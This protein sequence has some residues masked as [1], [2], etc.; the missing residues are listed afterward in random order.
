MNNS[1][2]DHLSNGNSIPI[3]KELYKYS[4]KMVQDGLLEPGI[5]RSFIT[6]HKNEYNGSQIVSDFLHFVFEL[7]YDPMRP[8][9]YSPHSKEWGRS[10]D[11]NYKIPEITSLW[12]DLS[13]DN[14][15]LMVK[16]VG[17][18]NIQSLVEQGYHFLHQAY[19]GHQTKAIEQLSSYDLSYDLKDNWGKTVEQYAK[20]DP[21]LVD[22]YLKNNQTAQ[23]FTNMKNWFVETLDKIAIYKWDKKSNIKKLQSWLNEKWNGFSDDE[24][25][26]LFSLT[27]GC[28]IRDPYLMVLNLLEDKKKHDRTR[29]P[30]WVNLKNCHNFNLAFMAIKG[31]DFLSYSE[32]NDLYFVEALAHVYANLDYETIKGQIS[33]TNISGLTP[34]QSILYHLAHGSYT[35]NGFTNI[36]DIWLEKIVDEEPFFHTMVKRKNKLFEVF[37]NDWLDI[38][39]INDFKQY[40]IQEPDPEC[41]QVIVE[42]EDT[43]ASYFIDKPSKDYSKYSRWLSVDFKFQKDMPD[44]I[45]STWLYKDTQ[46]KYSFEYFFENHY[47]CLK[48]NKFPKFLDKFISSIEKTDYYGSFNEYYE[49][50]V[51]KL[52]EPEIVFKMLKGSLYAYSACEKSGE[53]RYQYDSYTLG[54]LIKSCVKVLEIDPGIHPWQELTI[55]YNIE[56]NFYQKDALRSV[57]SY[58]VNAKL[59]QELNTKDNNKKLKI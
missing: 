26:E 28:H 44:P 58:I 20:N 27:S 10:E 55:P 4:P 40:Q 32:K 42:G 7:G 35:R 45:K 14:K 39:T 5:V 43:H 30:F 29:F 2:F 23:K 9:V 47:M 6:K 19:K 33:F 46:G 51:R 16:H 3:L 25:Q 41:Q 37:L 50:Q 18:Q 21:A 59:N 57:S 22:I 52:Y 11:N 34:D 8:V 38:Q 48:R 1:I 17:K 56:N 49:K 36:K 53:Y 24:Q 31:S 15:A 12:F 13:D 54:R